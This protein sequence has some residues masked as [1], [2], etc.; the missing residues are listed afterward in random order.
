MTYKIVSTIMIPC[1][2]ALMVKTAHAV[3][4]GPIVGAAATVRVHDFPE[5]G[6]TATLEWN[7]SGQKF[8]LVTV[9]T[10]EDAALDSALF[11]AIATLRD[12]DAVHTALDNGASVHARDA[13][14]ETPLY[15]SIPV[16]VDIVRL[17]LEA[18]ASVHARNAY[19][20]TPLHDASIWGHIEIVRLLLEA[21][22]DVNAQ[23]NRGWTPLTWVE[24]PP[25]GV[26]Q[27]SDELIQI[28]KD[29]GGE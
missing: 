4:E 22:A 7:E 14:G 29:A 12:V 6:Y 28:L 27:A 26:P 17:L 18:G 8:D 10:P 1:A 5:S 3:L 19:G 25:W 16:S 13:Q 23:D 24:D 11:F 2:L 15:A 20:M 21:G 9:R